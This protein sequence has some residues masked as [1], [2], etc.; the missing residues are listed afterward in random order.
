MIVEM[1]TAENGTKLSQL[2]MAG[3][4]SLQEPDS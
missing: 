3:G 2:L 1:A 4:L